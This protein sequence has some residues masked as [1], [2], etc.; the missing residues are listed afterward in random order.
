MLKQIPKARK[1]E[2]PT[3]SAE[4][5]AIE[6]RRGGGVLFTTTAATNTVKLKWFTETKVWPQNTYLNGSSK[7]ENFFIAGMDVVGGRSALPHGK[8]L[9]RSPWRSVGPLRRQFDLNDSAP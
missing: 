3:N 8:G 6:V 9:P 5:V 1:F 7:P 2:N 4:K